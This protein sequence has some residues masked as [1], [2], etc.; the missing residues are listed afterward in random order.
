MHLIKKLLP[1]KCKG[2]GYR[3]NVLVKVNFTKVEFNAKFD[4]NAFDTK[5]SMTSANLEVPVSGKPSSN[6][7]SVKYPTSKIDNLGLIDEEELNTATGKRAI[8][9]YTGKNKSYTLVEEQAE[10]DQTATVDATP[11]NGDVADLGFTFG[12]MTDHS[13]SWTQNGV[14]YMIASKNLTKNEM[15]E[16]ASSVQ[17]EPVK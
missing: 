4:N 12:E 13:L 7:L 1:C 8:L 2:Y 17:E 16:I 10:A 5:K 9:T 3:P 11:V 14:D 15:I 6:G